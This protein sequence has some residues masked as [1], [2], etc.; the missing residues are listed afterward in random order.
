MVSGNDQLGVEGA[1]LPEPLR[2]L[3]RSRSDGRV[4]TGVVVE[5]A[6]LSGA[7]AVLSSERTATDSVGE[8]ETRLTLGA[9]AGTYRV[10]ASFGGLVGEPAVF[11]AR[12]VFKP[13]ISALVPGSIV[14]GEPIRLHG[15]HFS[16]SRTGNLVLFD[17][18]RGV[19]FTATETELFVSVPRCLRGGSVD[20]WVSV[21]GVAGE[22]QS[23]L[24]TP[25]AP[26]SLDVGDW[27]VLPESLEPLCVRLPAAED[28]TYLAVA[29]SAST[30]AGGLHE[31]DVLV[32]SESGRLLTGVSEGVTPTGGPDRPPVLDGKQAEWDRG[33]RELENGLV[34]MIDRVEGSGSR[35]PPRTPEVGERR[36]FKV[37]NVDRDFDDVTAIIRHVSGRAVLYEDVT[38]PARGFS[39]GDFADLAAIFDDLIFPTVTGAY[40]EAS[41]LDSDGRIS[42]LMTPTVNR[43]TEPES[44][45]GV[46]GGFFFG[47]DLVR[48]NENSNE[49]E[50]FYTVVPDPEGD[51]GNALS[52]ER[53]LEVVP[54][55]LAHELQHMV[56]FNQRVLLRGAESTGSLWVSEALAQMAETVVAEELEDRGMVELAASYHAG[57]LD[58]ARRYLANPEQVSVVV[59]AGSGT[60]EE[61][62]AGWLLLRY[63]RAQAGTN[64]VLLRLTQTTRPG[65]ANV[66]HE[67][68]REWAQLLAE[69]AAAVY[70]DGGS[71]DIDPDFSIGLDP[72]LT[73][74]DL[75]LR[76]ALTRSGDAY[77]LAP[78]EVS[79]DVT[80]KW[81][82]QMWSSSSVYFL[83][84]PAL[85]GGL[86][87]SFSAPMGAIRGEEAGLQLSIVRLN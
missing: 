8:A 52:T 81:S 34:S 72:R 33:L 44:S 25:A 61:R 30:L 64:D 19:V 56:H 79:G 82:G 60:L 78:D 75:D 47:L 14:A 46:I 2:V 50:I 18:V 73:F 57:N 17:G 38:A 16:S 21:G 13:R 1:P 5:W 63:L 45:Q 80:F 32:P 74:P 12:V 68:E 36:Q 43:L 35:T 15:E 77:P 3:V 48:G 65:I 41:D 11:E 39:D 83:M 31:V 6:V 49:G 28:A 71:L 37:L 85:P 87:V 7:G 20:V 27:L 59:A 9:D 22:P 51:L 62:G 84:T 69:W 23:T 54:S 58:R 67:S 55:I 70:L 40:G 42:I 4:A 76:S 86:T 29:Q 66:E 24:V 53:V 10:Q 26:T